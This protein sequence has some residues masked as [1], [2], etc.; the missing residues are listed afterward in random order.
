MKLLI[1]LNKSEILQRVKAKAHKKG[2]TDLS[3][4]GNDASKYAYNEQA[5]DDEADQFVLMSSLRDSVGHFKSFIA[6]Y[7]QSDQ[8]LKAD[9][10]TDTLN[11]DSDDFTININVSERF[12]QSMLQP[13]ADAASKYIVD[14]MLMDW[15]TPIDAGQVKMY[16][17]L[18]K[19]DEA[20]IV[21]CFYKV[22]PHVPTHSYY[23]KISITKSPSIL[24]TMPI[25][26][27]I[28]VSSTWGVGQQMTIKYKND[29]TAK[30]DYIDDIVCETN[31]DCIKV[32]LTKKGY[33]RLTAVSEGSANIYVYSKHNPSVGVW[34]AVN[35]DY[36][37]E[38]Q[39]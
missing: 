11:D 28:S 29:S 15:Y 23:D 3:I 22:K 4:K 27:Q 7:I 33:F 9:N 24:N 5:G 26:E 25:G 16:A 17:D 1:N 34:G 32:E 18:L 10:I 6:E 20:H 38:I 31:D 19:V 35:V 14:D 39:E 13:L 12:N 8:T 30:K 37:T 2:I 36:N 21:H